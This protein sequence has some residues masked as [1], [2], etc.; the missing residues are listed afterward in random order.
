MNL[1]S[2]IKGLGQNQMRIFS[3][4]I[5]L[6]RITLG[7]GFG[8][9]IASAVLSQSTPTTDF[10]LVQDIGLAS[11]QGVKYDPNYDRFV[12][13]DAQGRLVLADASTYEIQH[14]LYEGGTYYGYEFSHNGRWLAVAQT[15]TVDVWDTE[16]GA[17]D[18]VLQPTVALSFSALLQFSD[19]DTLL[20]FKAIV[21]APDEIRISED[22]TTLA[23]WLWDLEAERGNRAGTLPL[24]RRAQPF[25]DLRTELLLAPNNKL[26]AA[27]PRSVSVTDFA[28]G[29]YE[30]ITELQTSRFEFDPIDIW[31]SLTGESVYF[32]AQNGAY[33]QLNT[34]GSNSWQQLPI[35]RED[36]SYNLNP[37]RFA[38]G[39]V[40]QPIGTTN[41]LT[42]NSF[43]RLLLGSQYHLD[44][45]P[46]SVTLVDVLQPVT[47][48]KSESGF[49]VYIFNERS[50]RGTLELVRPPSITDF[51]LSPD[52]TQVAVRRDAPER[53]LEIYAL[54]TG[55]LITSIVPRFP[56]V[57]QNSVFSYDGSGSTLLSGWERY[58]V[59]TGELLMAAPRY[60]GSFEDF[61]FSQDDSTLVTLSNGDLTLWDIASGEPTRREEVMLNGD[62]IARSADGTRYLTALLSE[63]GNN[64]LY[65]TTPSGLFGEPIPQPAAAPLFD[66]SITD[67][68]ELLASIQIPS[69]QVPIGAGIEIYDILRDERKQLFYE[70]RPHNMIRQVIASPDWSHVLVVFE[71]DPYLSSGLSTPSSEVAIYSVE[72]GLRWY[73]SDDDL[74]AD[75][76]RRYGWLDN[77]TA[78]VLSVSRRDTSPP[79]RIYGLEYHVS[80]LPQCLVDAFPNDWTQWVPLWEQL[81]GTLR[82]DALGRLTERLCAEPLASVAQVEAIFSPSPTPTRPPIQAT[83][84]RIAGLPL[85]LSQAYGRNAGAFAPQWRALTAGLTDAEISE[86]EDILCEGLNDGVSIPVPNLSGSNT[87]SRLQAITINIATGE[88]TLSSTLTPPTA[89]PQPLAPVLQAFRAQYGFMPS[90][91][92]LSN[93]KTL[94]AIQTPGGQVRVYRL[95]RAYETYINALAATQAAA[96]AAQPVAV[97]LLATPTPV[98]FPLGGA[99]PTLTP[100]VTLTPPPLPQ[101]THP[102][103]TALGEVSRVCSATQIHSVEQP[104][105]G[106]RPSGRILTTE[107]YTNRAE[108]M[109]YDP[110][111]GQARLGEAL[112]DS[113]Q[114]GQLSPMRDWLLLQQDEI[115]VAN[116]D[117]SA[118]VV[119][120][121]AYE[122]SAFPR[123]VQWI[124]ND[125]LQ[126]VYDGYLP[127]VSMGTY[128]LQTDYNVRSGEYSAPITPTPRAEINN[129]PTQLISIQPIQRQWA[130]L[131]VAFD[132]GTQE[133]WR[134]Y[135]LNTGTGESSYF[136]RV[137]TGR[138][139]TIRW[140]PDGSSMF[141]QVEQDDS[142]YLFRPQEQ[143]HWR[144]GL[145]FYPLDSGVWSRD[146]RYQA[147]WI[148]RDTPTLETLL[149]VWDS[150]TGSLREYC[151][152]DLVQVGQEQALF[153]SV[154]GGYVVFLGALKGD[155][156]DEIP[157][158]RTLVLDLQTGSVTEISRTVERLI[159]WTE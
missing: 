157:Q 78:F 77:Q 48:D 114:R 44:E 127:E 22:D 96:Q 120:Y 119:L 29:S 115:I 70:P 57:P 113:T 143:S 117:G 155:S 151:V 13:V 27:L 124:N 43:L 147:R 94:L 85:C 106:Y 131:S 116:A 112:V 83:S 134:Y 50:G 6:L 130:V 40:A 37:R 26:I 35:G 14:T 2:F 63:T 59:V 102:A 145:G 104:P 92:R 61:V 20:M 139:L 72:D 109:V 110:A 156:I 28:S 46:L 47:I 9:L 15:N 5:P 66:E 149:Q 18:L 91:A 95:N 25:F 141:Y 154:D 137:D 7:L 30:V 53:P 150:Q 24:S 10:S 76:N 32:R 8:L 41:T 1:T 33:Y 11:P 42:S 144:L 103:Y 67:P 21:P 12:M 107:R 19:D 97:S 4:K 125:T 81:N 121:E 23:P 129:L 65:V 128:T 49:L 62:L 36:F 105:D 84:S 126:I 58:D 140:T 158:M 68:D 69:I 71:R 153:W 86:V 87:S 52:G 136:A 108:I 39:G 55:N 122:Q 146:A 74:P 31:Y 88:R 93:D 135:L 80:G 89:Q 56:S 138:P 64:S 99:R 60:H 123:S 17:R 3:L 34:N 142:T 132:T 75:R 79:Q 38:F 118:P 111:N 148:L 159:L 100:T 98:G 101:A 73:F 133:G 82:T 90:V 152:P 54:E 51:A 16:S 45:S